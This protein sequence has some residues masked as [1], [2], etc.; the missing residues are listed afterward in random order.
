VLGARR[1]RQAIELAERHGWSEE[2]LAGVAYAQLAG[3]LV[4]Q[5]QLDEAQRSI[6]RAERTLRAELEPAAEMDEHEW[7]AAFTR[8]MMAALR[9]ADDDPQAATVAL[10]PAI[11]GTVPSGHPTWPVE[12]LLLEAVA[13][14]ALGDAG[15]AQRAI[16][17]ALDLA[18]PDGMLLPFL[19]HPARELLERH[20][21]RP[22]SRCATS[23]TSS[24]CLCTPSRHIPSSDPPEWAMPTHPAA[25]EAS[26]K[27][28]TKIP[29]GRLWWVWL[30]GP[31]PALTVDHPA[32][33]AMNS[34]A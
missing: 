4:S 30:I 24:T 9:L 31:R 33:L 7:D 29:R 11:A 2:P 6:E 21:C 8:T 19:L 32:S 14:D 26:A 18:E 5:G 23:E 1:S 25:R 15:A 17:R 34:N 13:R 12:A 28:P 22:T 27:S 3:A 20:T 10:A 16:E